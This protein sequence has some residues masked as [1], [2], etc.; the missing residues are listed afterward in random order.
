MTTLIAKT[1]TALLNA[2][3]FAIGL[4]MVGLGF[5]FV[6]TI[7]LFGIVAVGVAMIASLFVTLEPPKA[8]DAETVS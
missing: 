5:A 6:G 2:T 8:T 7:A 4:F 3:L 1:K